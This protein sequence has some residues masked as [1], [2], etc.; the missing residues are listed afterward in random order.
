MQRVQEKAATSIDHARKGKKLKFLL[1]VK[2]NFREQAQKR[3]RVKL[4][5]IEQKMNKLEKYFD[6]LKGGLES[7]GDAMRPFLSYLEEKV[8]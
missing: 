2:K 5:S 1:K 8:F 4:G 3:L 7:V 6:N